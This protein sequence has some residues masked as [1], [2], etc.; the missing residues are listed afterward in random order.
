MNLI[1]IITSSVKHYQDQPKARESTAAPLTSSKPIWG[2]SVKTTSGPGRLC[3]APLPAIR[4]CFPPSLRLS[5]PAW[6]PDGAARPRCPPG[7]A[8]APGLPRLPGALLQSREGAHCSRPPADSGRWN[9][10]GSFLCADRERRN[11]CKPFWKGDSAL[12]GVRCQTAPPLRPAL[13]L[14]ACGFVTASP[15]HA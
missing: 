1:N 12:A 2:R 10:C 15:N 4:C 14:G 8:S 13:Q 9:S 5:G 3:L 7:P 11:P 6:P